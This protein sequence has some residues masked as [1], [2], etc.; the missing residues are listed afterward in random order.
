V[1]AGA[2]KDAPPKQAFLEGGRRLP[3]AVF[4]DAV[5]AREPGEVGR[6][7]AAA[8][9]PDPLAAALERHASDPAALEE[10]LL[11]ARNALLHARAWWDPMGPATVLRYVLQLRAEMLDLRRAIWGV[12]LG[13]SAAPEP[14]L[15][16][17]PA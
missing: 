3:L 15:G 11:R 9:R 5:A 14:A 12:A 17:V 13:A 7:L 10:A 6:R 16:L 2:E 4:L 1:L 8:F